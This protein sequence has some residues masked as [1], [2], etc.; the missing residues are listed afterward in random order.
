MVSRP[1][2]RTSRELAGLVQALPHLH[3]DAKLMALDAILTNLREHAPRVGQLV[4]GIVSGLD[5]LVK[6]NLVKEHGVYHGESQWDEP[7]ALADCLVLTVK[8]VELEAALA[9]F[10]V[11][12]LG[13]TIVDGDLRVWFVEHDDVRF[14]IAKVGTDGN[15]ESAIVFGRLYAA[16][17]P[18]SAV[19][20]GMAG[21]LAG[22]VSPGDVVVAQHVHAY[23][24]RKLT[25]VGEKRR[26]KTYRVDDVLLRQV[27]D[28]RIVRKSWPTEVADDLRSLIR[29]GH[30]DDDARL[31]AEDWRPKVVRGDVL[32]GA[33][34]IEDD[35]LAALAEQHHD[36]V[37]AVEMEGAGFAAA[38]DEVRIPWLVIRGIADV[39]DE[40]RDDTWQFGSTYVAAR[41][42][43]DGLALGIVNLQ[44]A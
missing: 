3:G 35:S 40:N 24:F 34:L 18:R 12:V 28:M 20:L 31:P 4:A 14:C 22:K 19:L 23:D 7:T 39:G 9:A 32:A 43:R 30:A 6:E 2:T 1:Q 26:A 8:S 21:G 44:L 11:D 29:G 33:S 25:K 38:A 27:E 37:R 42:L 36:R 13:H 10:D 15:S 5:P 16:L 41:F 17:H